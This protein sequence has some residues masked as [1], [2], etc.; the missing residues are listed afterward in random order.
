MTDRPISLEWS[1]D[2]VFNRLRFSG[3]VDI[4][5][6]VELQVHFHPAD[7][8]VLADPPAGAAGVLR[9]LEVI[10]RRAEDQ[11]LLS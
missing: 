9:A 10:F 1:V 2:R 4:D 5:Q 3:H 8:R 7:W 6:L 11:G